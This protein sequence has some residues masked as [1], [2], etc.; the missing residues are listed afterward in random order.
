MCHLQKQNFYTQHFFSK[1]GIRN[2][3]FGIRNSE[4]GIRNSEFG[5]RNSE[6][7]IRNS[8]LRIRIEVKKG[9][10]WAI[11]QRDKNAA[12]RVI[13]SPE[14]NA[15]RWAYSRISLLRRPSVVHQSVRHSQCTNISSETAWSIKPKFYVESLWIRETKVCSRH[16]GHMTKMVTRPIYVKSLQTISS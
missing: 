2:S 12:F 8:E 5:I 1:C 15:R 10:I 13:S 7:R 3:E 11:V 14:P 6:F 4:F 16:L 9:T